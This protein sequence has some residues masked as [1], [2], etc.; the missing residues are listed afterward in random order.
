M[1]QVLR[2]VLCFSLL[3]L[4]TSSMLFGCGAAPVAPASQSASVA[5]SATPEVSASAEATASPEASVA[6]ASTDAA[7]AATALEWQSDTS[8][9]TMSVYIDFPQDQ[10]LGWGKDRVSAEITKRT[11]V[12][13]DLKT[14]TTTDSQELN[15]M[16]ASNELPDFVIVSANGPMQSIL[17]KQGFAAP[18]NKLI[19]QYAPKMWTVLSADQVKVYSESDKNLY[20][21]TDYYCD[22]EKI[23]TLKGA[24]IQNGVFAID[25][26]IWADAG[27]PPIT[28]LDEYK[29]ALLKV[30][31][32]FPELP[33][34]A[35]DDM[36]GSPQDGQRNMAQ[37]INRLYGGSHQMALGSDGTIHINFRD[38]TYK[39]A[40]MYINDLYRSGLINP[41]NFT[42]TAEQRKDFYNGKVFSYWG[43]PYN[44]YSRDM[45]V[46]G[47]NVPVDVPKVPGITP[48]LANAAT[49]I[50]GW[51]AVHISKTS[52]NQERAIKY[53]EFMISDE[54]QMLMNFGVE[55]KDFTLEE[56]MPKRSAET[57]EASTKDWG[58][59]TKTFGVYNY[60]IQWLASGWI[61]MNEYYWASKENPMF[62][63]TVDIYS[64]Y[65]TNERLFDLIKVP[66][67]SD[68]KVIETKILDLWKTTLPKLYL[69]KTEADLLA[70]YAE[71]IKQAENLGLAKLEAAY[72]VSYNNWKSVLG[73]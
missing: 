53:L 31:E 14:A 18:L 37:T 63:A 10:F 36:F 66:N 70:N 68:E 46:N 26:K 64:K 5:A 44:F 39:K 2:R 7:P 54:G 30:K 8:P 19:D 50:G 45:S 62:Q 23:A 34:Y 28:T 67:D 11:G 21:L 56:G 35:Y 43:Q 47:V 17:W 40:L 29:A 32:K 48:K 58:V 6:P 1:K 24:I 49:G 52:K 60:N 38:E 71:L 16:L 13:L 9:V 55:G 22:I 59:F 20:M 3:L 12:T 15:L 25:K 33:F 4:L 41:E 51:H 42:V 73:D 65:A 72:T 27:S 69:A 57:K 61:D